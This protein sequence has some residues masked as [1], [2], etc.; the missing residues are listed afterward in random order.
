MGGTKLSTS[1]AQG[2]EFLNSPLFCA[3]DLHFLFGFQVST[4]NLQ[5]SISIRPPISFR[6]RSRKLPKDHKSKIHLH[7]SAETSQLNMTLFLFSS[8]DVCIV[9]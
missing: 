5:V 9:M 4:H 2:V 7:L 6:G 1:G 8:W 3:S